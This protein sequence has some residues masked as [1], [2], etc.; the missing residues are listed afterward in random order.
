MSHADL[1]ELLG[2]YAIDA[3]EPDEI[4]AV[5]RHLADCP[6]CRAEVTGHHEV[7]SMLGD[8]GGPAPAS[9]WTR[10]AGSLEE[11]PPPFRL[12]VAD[13]PATASRRR[14][15]RGLTRGLIGTAAVAAAVLIAVL[16]IQVVRLNNRTNQLLPAKTVSAIQAAAFAAAAQGDGRHTTLRSADGKLKVETVV[17]PNGTGFVLTDNL[18][19]LPKAQ[20]Y[21]LWGL[22]GSDRISLG[23]LGNQP[24][25]AMF[26]VEGRTLGLAV[27]TEAA[28]G[29]VRSGQT[30]VVLG[31]LGPGS[32]GI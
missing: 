8:S 7:A 11:P 22:V 23:V 16:G 30:P 31:W 21:Q 10:I 2:A 25:V 1:Q 3:L 5:E 12:A 17:L 29:V 6:K 26:R 15:R 32:S 28:G 24:Q 14:W 27:T 18:P 13:R 19:T 9:L 20:T 4:E